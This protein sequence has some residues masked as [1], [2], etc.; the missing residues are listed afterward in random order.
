MMPILQM[1]E[2]R[3]RGYQAKVTQHVGDK[4]KCELGQSDSCAFLFP[5]LSPHSGVS[6]LGMGLCF[7]HFCVPRPDQVGARHDGGVNPFLLHQILSG[8]IHHVHLF[9]SSSIHAHFIHS[10]MSSP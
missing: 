4:Q 1:R 8:P 7:L 2:L 5:H 9:S 3:H 10:N 6:S